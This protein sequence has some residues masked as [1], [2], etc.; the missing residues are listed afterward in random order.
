M[1]SVLVA[2]TLA[3]LVATTVRAQNLQT[4][5][6]TASNIAFVAEA[7]GKMVDGKQKQTAADEIGAASEAMAEGKID[8]CKDHLLKATLQTK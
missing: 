6:C 4:R 1:K 3:L 8:A 5:D 7:I 2:I